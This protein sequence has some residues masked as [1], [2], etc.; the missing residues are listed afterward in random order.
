MNYLR[1]AT[2]VFDCGKSGMGKTSWAIRYINGCSCDR[3]FIY[4]HQNEFA[5]RLEIPPDKVAY[6]PDDFL[7]LAETQRVVC[8][9]FTKNYPGYKR[10]M[11]DNFS[12]MVFEVCKF[13]LTPKGKQALFVCDELQQF[14]T[15]NSI[16]QAPESFRMI[17]ETGRRY[18]LDTLMLSRAPNRVNVAI[19]EEFT[20]LILFKLNDETSL[21]FAK[22]VG[23]D[24]E[25]VK[26]LAPHHYLYYNIITGRDGS[27]KLEFKGRGVTEKTHENKSLTRGVKS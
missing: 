16:E 20:E 3:I 9:D 13:G 4:D 8:F 1:K 10:E 14:V 24:I 6:T 21:K 22:E 7:R 18:N 25:A 5:Q 23:A 12:E 26:K 11:F 15:G 27:A 17:M 19:R 2:H